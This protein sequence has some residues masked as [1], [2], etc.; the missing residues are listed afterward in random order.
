M[1]AAV[2]VLHNKLTTGGAGLWKNCSATNKNPY[3]GLIFLLGSQILKPLLKHENDDPLGCLDC[4]Y[5]TFMFE[6][7]FVELKFSVQTSAAV[8]VVR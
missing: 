3:W 8:P 6:K 5:T 7:P 4:Y 2:I 1:F